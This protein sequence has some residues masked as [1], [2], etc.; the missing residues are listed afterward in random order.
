MGIRRNIRAANKVRKGLKAIRED[1]RE[2]EPKKTEKPK[3][4]K[5]KK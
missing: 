3:K 2:D 1:V 4:P 5:K